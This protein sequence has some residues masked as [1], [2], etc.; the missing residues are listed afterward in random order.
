MPEA[1]RVPSPAYERGGN[2]LPQGEASSV[3]ALMGLVGPTQ[4]PPTYKPQNPQEQFLFAP[5]DRPGEP[6][7]A[8]APVG[9]GS[10]F[11]R[12]ADETDAEFKMRMAQ[13]ILKSPNVSRES[14]AWAAR[15]AAGE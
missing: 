6:V 15:A 5:T 9:P 11:N 8:G 10:D 3:N 13:T 1:G 7:T 14:K 12:Y 4:E 2:N